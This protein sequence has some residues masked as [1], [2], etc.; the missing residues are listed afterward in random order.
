MPISVFRLAAL[1]FA[2]YLP[3]ASAFGASVA[4]VPNTTT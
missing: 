3:F 2:A 4:G 1:L